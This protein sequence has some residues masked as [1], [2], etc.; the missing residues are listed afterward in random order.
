MAN[1]AAERKQMK[2]LTD[3]MEAGIQEL[4]DSDKFKAYLTTMSRFHSLQYP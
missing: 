2:E 3:R 4:L 1:A